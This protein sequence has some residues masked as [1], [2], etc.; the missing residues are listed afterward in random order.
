MTKYD[1]AV[2]DGLLVLIIF[3]GPL[4]LVLD[5]IISHFIYKEEAD[6]GDEMFGDTQKLRGRYATTGGKDGKPRKPAKNPLLIMTKHT[7]AD[8]DLNDGGDLGADYDCN[9][10]SFEY[11]RERVQEAWTDLEGNARRAMTGLGSEDCFEPGLEDSGITIPDTGAPDEPA[12]VAVAYPKSSRLNT[13]RKIHE[14]LTVLVVLA[15]M[16]WLIYTMAYTLK[17][18]EYDL[19]DVTGL[20][21]DKAQEVQS[22]MTNWEDNKIEAGVIVGICADVL[23]FFTLLTTFCCCQGGSKKAALVIKL[24]VRAVK[25]V[26]CVCARVMSVRAEAC[27]IQS[28][29]GALRTPRVVTTNQTNAN[30][31]HKIHSIQFST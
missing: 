27:I 31:F 11:M 15:S 18:D 25:G 30:S 24:L 10:L 1:K 21:A 20:A 16:G 22:Y 26:W 3:S 14:Y 4:L 7:P 12:K 19:S 13:F 23:L 9:D 2:F 29:S 17:L 5:P 8:R 28:Q 6:V